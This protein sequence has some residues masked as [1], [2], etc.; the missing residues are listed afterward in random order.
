MKRLTIIQHTSAEYLGFLEDHFEGRNIGFRYVRPFTEGTSLP[1]PTELGDG[2]ILLGGGPWGSAGGRDVPTLRGEAALARYALDC[3]LPLVGFGLGAQ[4]VAL[5]AGGETEAT[6]LIFEIG[7]A[8]RT[9]PDALGGLLPE[10][11]P[12]V[13]YM[14]DRPK[15]PAYARVLARDDANRPA[16]FQIGERALGFVAHPGFKAAI[17][18]DLIMEFEESPPDPG[19]KLQQLRDMRNELEGALASLAAGIVARMGWME[20]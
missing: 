6:P 14:R 7:H 16:I 8:R 18:E 3:G 20:P 1:G 9:D 15:P 4:I 19:P 10:R 12:Q 5:A 2:L 11:L 13:L 17:A